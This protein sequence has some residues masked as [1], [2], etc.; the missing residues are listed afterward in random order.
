MN[1]TVAAN[2]ATFEEKGWLLL[3]GALTPE[4]TEQCRVALNT[5]RAN[6]WEEGLNR[7]GN[8]WFDSLLE[9]MPGRPVWLTV[10]VTLPARAYQPWPLRSGMAPGFLRLLAAER[11]RPL[12]KPCDRYQ[13]DLLFSG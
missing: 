13:Y 5:A 8:M 11:R 3:P 4:E 6:G 10:S 9:R 2:L 12:R 1:E 7:V